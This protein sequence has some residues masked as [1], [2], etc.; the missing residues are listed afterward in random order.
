M[1]HINGSYRLTRAFLIASLVLVNLLAHGQTAT[2]VQSGSAQGLNLSS[3]SAAFSSSNTAGNLIIAFVR[4]DT[5]TQTVTITDSLGNSYIRAVSETQS[6][7]GHQI[8]IFYAK[9]I[10]AGSNT[11]TATFSA[12]NAHS[13]LAI[14]EYAG[15]GTNVALDQTA[16][17]TG[18][19]K[20][21][22]TGNTGTTRNARELLFAALGIPYSYSG[23]V[24]AG[25]GYSLQ[26]Q[27]TASARAADENQI[28]SA[29]G[30]Y[31]GT[32]SLSSNANWSAAMA[33]FIAAPAVTTSSLP[34]AT[35]TAAYSS[36]LAANGGTGAYNWS[37]VS[38]SLPAGLSLNATTGAI[39]GTPT[40]S[41]S[42][43]FTVQVSDANGNTGTKALGITVNPVPT[44]T[45]TALPMGRLTV[46]YSATLQ[47]SGGT[48]PLTWS[49][50]SG[51]LP[52]GLTLNTSTGAIT[53][54]PTA[55]GASNFTAQVTDANS[56][57]ATQALSITVYGAVIDSLS[58]SLLLLEPV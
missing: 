38:G 30:T 13:W 23:T 4:M 50:A 41:G 55:A 58:P 22:T 37:V 39:S 7:D 51:S 45:T 56:A 12:A 25:T 32:F 11:V 48:A 24:T 29:T 19:N 28:V 27:N 17:G 47:A 54:T 52:A 34:A 8:S 16:H 21:P 6:T 15:L 26:Q 40:A 42:S 31:A 1:K 35:Q 20:S 2:L 18:R 44:I 5:T 46:A 10:R 43:S 14:Y 33:T 57:V 9:N 36:T 49:I 53:G 3:V